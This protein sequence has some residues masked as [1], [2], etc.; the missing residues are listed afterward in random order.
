MPRINRRHGG[1]DVS[2]ITAKFTYRD[3]PTDSHEAVMYHPHIERVK[4]LTV[5]YLK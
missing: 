3:N 5:G 4:I 1:A 2:R